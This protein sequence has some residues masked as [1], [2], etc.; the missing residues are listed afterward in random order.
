MV[1]MAPGDEVDLRAMLSFALSLDGPAAIRYPKAAAQTIE[2]D[3]APIELGRAEVLDWGHDGMLIACG[4][5][6]N[7]CLKAAATLREEGIDVGVINARFVKPLDNATILRALATSPFVITV[8]EAALMGGFGSAVVEA[9]VDAGVS[10]SHVRRLGIP[11]RFIEHA[12]RN[13]LLT[14]LGLDA[15]GIAAACRDM[16]ARRDIKAPDRRRVS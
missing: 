3:R 7:T 15:D 13:E 16:A 11:D 8:E 2:A 6:V 14:D 1:V 4:T 5:L 10:T 12:E 9:A